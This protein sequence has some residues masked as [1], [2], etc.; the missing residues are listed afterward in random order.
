MVKVTFNAE[1]VEINHE[2]KLTVTAYMEKEDMLRMLDIFSVEEVLNHFG[3]EKLLDKMGIGTCEKR[4]MEDGATLPFDLESIQN[5]DT[6]ET[7][8]GKS[9][10]IIC[11]EAR[12][13]YPVSA[14]VRMEDGTDLLCAYTVEGKCKTQ[15]EDYD[16]VILRNG[17]HVFVARDKD[18]DLYAYNYRPIRMEESWCCSSNGEFMNL[19]KDMYPEVNWDDE[20]PTELVVRKDKNANKH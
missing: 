18:G 4:N 12:G 14:L 8:G 2:M 11:T 3:M 9:V 20:R 16:L 5:D 1:K 6:I 19:D 15:D 10:E 17:K 13:D 7:K